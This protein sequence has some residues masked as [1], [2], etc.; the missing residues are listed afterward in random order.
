MDKQDRHDC[1]LHGPPALTEVLPGEK[2]LTRGQCGDSAE[3][4]TRNRHGL[5]GSQRRRLLLDNE[6]EQRADAPGQPSCC[7]LHVHHSHRCGD[8][9][10]EREQAGYVTGG[11]PSAGQA[12]PVLP[13]SPSALVLAGEEGKLASS[14]PSAARGMTIHPLTPPLILAKT[15]MNSQ[16]RDR[17]QKLG[18]SDHLFALRCSVCPADRPLG[19]SGRQVPAGT[20]HT[21]ESTPGLRYHGGEV[22]TAVSHFFLL[23]P[24]AARATRPQLRPEITARPAGGSKASHKRRGFRLRDVCPPRRPRRGKEPQTKQAL[25]SHTQFLG[26]G[27]RGA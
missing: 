13:M 10:Q 19:A 17:H 20:G 3:S 8:H 25:A 24:D 12:W 27:R 15:N 2:N 9:G 11:A 14:Q 23:L 26:G 5:A 6:L 4:R 1:P 22:P 21:Q 16:P 18:P 7:N